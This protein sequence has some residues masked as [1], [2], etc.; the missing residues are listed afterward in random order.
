VLA[1]ASAA[2]IDLASITAELEPEGVASF[3]DSYRELL[4]CI[5]RKL[6]A[7]EAVGS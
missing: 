1:D 7:P 3:C 5:D 2:G 4:D 6:G